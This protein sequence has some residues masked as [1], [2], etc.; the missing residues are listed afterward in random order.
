LRPA[1]YTHLGSR[2][3]ALVVDEFGPE[4]GDALPGNEGRAEFLFV[5]ERDFRGLIGLA[6]DERESTVSKKQDQIDEPLGI[7]D[8][9]EHA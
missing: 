7:C 5:S 2:K 9:D 8:A 6:A 1:G 4:A 3:D